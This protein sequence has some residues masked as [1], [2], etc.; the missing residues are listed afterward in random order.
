MLRP[1][2]RAT[3]SDE[4]IRVVIASFRSESEVMDI[5]KETVA[6]ARNHASTAIA[7]HDFPASSRRNR[8][9]RASITHVG[10]KVQVLRVTL[11][12]LHDLRS[13]LDLLPSPLL[14]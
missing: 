11:G 2:M 9:A 12:H 6:T 8:L 1:V 5:Q 4:T 14:P 3:Q 13:H 7:P 10:G